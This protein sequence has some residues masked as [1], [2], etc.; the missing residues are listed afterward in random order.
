MRGKQVRYGAEPS[1]FVEVWDAPS[2]GNRTIVFFHGG[3][4]RATYDLSLMDGLCEDM[5]RRGWQAVNVE[6]RRE[7]GWPAMAADVDAAWDVANVISGGSPLVA[8]G[9]SAGGHLALWAA[10]TARPKPTLA[11]SLAGC[12]DLAMTDS[13]NLGDGA[14]RDLVGNDDIADADPV[15][16]LPTGVRTLLVAPK[17]DFV[18]PQAVSVSYAEKARAAGDDVT[19][20]EP[21]GDHYLVLDPA[22]EPWATAAAYIEARVLG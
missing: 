14:A 11:V 13:L 5:V 1:Q 15:T 17:D 8:A 9:H 7:Q 2:T 18:V 6:Y 21:A 19:L 3:F 20:A 12:A 4:W 10:A 16:R 22:G